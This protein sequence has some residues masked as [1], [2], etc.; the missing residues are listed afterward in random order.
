MISRI[1]TCQVK[2][3]RLNEFRTTLN[4]QFLARI[5]RQR[6]F[7]DLVESL[8]TNTGTFVCNTFWNTPLD[9][10]KYDTSLFP[11][12]ATAL[13]PMLQTDPT[14]QTLNV[15]NST[16]HNISGGQKSAAA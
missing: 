15:E 9:V 10:E 7:V 5:Q 12:I 16:L 11:E 13:T 8:D 1:V 3:E 6:G 2:P 4:Q 14:V